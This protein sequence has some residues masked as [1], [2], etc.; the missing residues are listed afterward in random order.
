VTPCEG[1]GTSKEEARARACLIACK[2]L[3]EL[4]LL[5][6]YLESS[7]SRPALLE[8]IRSAFLSARDDGVR[9]QQTFPRLLPQR[10]NLP[11]T[12]LTPTPLSSENDIAQ[13]SDCL[14]SINRE[15]ERENR[16]GEGEREALGYVVEAG[17]RDN[18]VEVSV[19]GL[20][21]SYFHYR[22]SKKAS[23]AVIFAGFIST[24]ITRLIDECFL[25][26]SSVFPVDEPSHLDIIHTH[27]KSELT[28]S[29]VRNFFY[30]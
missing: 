20:E 2:K 27:A 29:K 25:C 19:C 13:R 8:S 30:R 3:Y 18:L 4:K 24:I 28:Q 21:C 16:E 12:T 6:S 23:R 17:V 1:E 22:Q 5:N 7:I 10:S 26:F 15:E 11:L 9:I 14:E